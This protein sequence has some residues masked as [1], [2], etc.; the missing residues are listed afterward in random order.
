MCNNNIFKIILFI[1]YFKKL[2]QDKTDSK[3]RRA[4][5]KKGQAVFPEIS[6]RYQQKPKIH[7]KVYFIYLFY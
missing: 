3:N 2:L 4:S 6:K 5:L 7:Y 1:N